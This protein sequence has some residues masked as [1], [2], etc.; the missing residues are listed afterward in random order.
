MK[1]Q[2]YT[3]TLPTGRTACTEPQCL[4]KG[5]L[6]LTLPGT[7]GGEKCQSDSWIFRVLWFPSAS[8]VRPMLH[9]YVTFIYEQSVTGT[10]VCH[11]SKKK[12]M[13]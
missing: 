13:R 11:S 12:E 8:I 6:Y 10:V 7:C 3:S 2:S 9:I 5:A 4:Y 1:G